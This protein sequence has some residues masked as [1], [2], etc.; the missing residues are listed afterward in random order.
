MSA[1]VSA[2]RS[3]SCL[4]RGVRCMPPAPLTNKGSPSK[5][6][7]RFNAL[8]TAGWL[9]PSRSAARVTLHSYTAPEASALVNTQ[10]VET[11]NQLHII[12][13]QFTQGFAA[14]A[15]AYADSLGKPIVGLYLSHAHPDHILGAS[16]FADVPFMTTDAVVADTEG[17]AGLYAS[18]KEQMGDTTPLYAP[19]GGLA[20]GSASWDGVAVEIAQIED[21]EAANTLTFHFPEAG[22]II[23]QDLLYASAH[24]FPL[25]NVSN[26]I[27]ALEAI[28]DTEGLKVI[29]AGHGLPA[30]PGAVDD[31]IA[32]LRFQNEVIA[33]SADAKAAVAAITEAYPRYGGEDL[34]AFVNF[35]FQ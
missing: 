22:L 12:D 10:I 27:A 35:R 33:N 11:A 6:L 5:F 16:Q 9:R 34:L 25:G 13:A 1:I 8:L 28:R 15:R 23:A 26:W 3:D 2:N 30:S 19:S 24:A 7:A 20:T 4:P 31:A 18:R 14:E 21:A 29:G 32:Y 17:S